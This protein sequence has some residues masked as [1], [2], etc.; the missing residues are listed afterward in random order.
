[1]PNFYMSWCFDGSAPIIL[2]SGR[3]YINTSNR[4]SDNILQWKYCEK[5]VPGQPLPQGPLFH[6]QV[7]PHCSDSNIWRMPTPRSPIAIWL[8]SLLR[9]R[10]SIKVFHRPD[11]QMVVAGFLS[12]GASG[13]ICGSAAGE[14][15]VQGVVLGEAD[16][17]SWPPSSNHAF[18]FE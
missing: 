10:C 4:F 15:W 14:Q 17:Q 3:V 18:L 8:S 5:V 2:F 7:M 9:S 12:S 13:V 16:P 1:M 11:V 6:S